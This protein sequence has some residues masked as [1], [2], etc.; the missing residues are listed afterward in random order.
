M[1]RITVHN[2][3]PCAIKLLSEFMV[4]RTYNSEYRRADVRLVLGLPYMHIPS[5]DL[6]V[7]G[8]LL[9]QPYLAAVNCRHRSLAN[10]WAACVGY[11]GR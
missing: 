4:E 6:S 5:P 3:R 9:H 7:L 8:F 11:N 2:V 10:C 1:L